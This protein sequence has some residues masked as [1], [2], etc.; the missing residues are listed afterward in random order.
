MKNWILDGGCW[1]LDAR[2]WMLDFVFSF[3]L[4]NIQYLE[5]SILYVEHCNKTSFNDLSR[6]IWACIRVTTSHR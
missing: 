3:L 5:S 4:L 2:C 6:Y 1:I